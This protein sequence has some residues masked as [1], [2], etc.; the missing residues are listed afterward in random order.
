MQ[1]QANFNKQLTLEKLAR[2]VD[3]LCS[4]VEGILKSKNT[5]IF[6]CSEI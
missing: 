4:E 5:Y 6:D 1:N 2:S 3:I